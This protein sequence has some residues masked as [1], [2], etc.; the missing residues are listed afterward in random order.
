MFLKFKRR[1]AAC[2]ILAWFALLAGVTRSFALEPS[3]PLGRLG[4][5][6]WTMENGLPQNT[7]P[8]LLQSHDGFIWAGTE[9]GLTRFDGIGFR[10]FD[11]AT[12]AAFPDAEIR[13][14]LDAGREGGLWIG[15]GDGLIRWKD[16]NATRFTTHEGLPGN[17]IRDLSQTSDG[18]VWVWTE[19]GLAR[20]TG[21][22]FQSASSENGLPGSEVTSIAADS[23]AGLWVGT[24]RGAFVFRQGHWQVMSN[25]ASAIGMDPRSSERP[26]LVK[27]IINRDVLLSSGDGIFREHDGAWTKILAKEALPADGITFLDRLSDGTVAAASKSSVVLA[28]GLN[29]SG[30]ATVRFTVSKELPGSR[31]ESMYADREGCLWIGTSRGLAR[32]TMNSGRMKEATVQLFPPSDPLA[33]NAVI[34][35]LEDREG[36]LWA[37]TETSGLQILRDAR[38]RVIGTSDG[39]NSDTT[40]AVMQDAQRILW[41]GTRDNGLNR[42]LE[43]ADGQL[44]VSTMTTANGLPSNVILSLAASPNGE[45]WIGTPDGLSRVG[46]DGMHSYSSAD[47]LADDFIRSLL[48]M[49]DN[50]G[51][52][53]HAARPDAHGS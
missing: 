45:T 22:R 11:H 15:T 13:C 2:L 30:R 47:G 36:D 31:I 53:W 20:W 23:S 37:G 32:V 18:A 6:A 35:L 27:S 48:V 5:Q 12:D 38:F 10:T 8:V 42:V 52:D 49:P 41:I 25:A 1:I 9:L 3:T 24:T 44:T 4:R 50:S 14:L 29:S 28:Q 7:V 46:H 40:T 16:G 21:D 51:V 33:S 26:A 17:A 19:G 39:L 43:G 34:S